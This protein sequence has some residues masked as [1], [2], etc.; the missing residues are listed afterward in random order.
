[1]FDEISFLCICS[2][3]D[4]WTSSTYKHYFLLT[5]LFHYTAS[6]VYIK[7]NSFLHIDQSQFPEGDL[8]WFCG[9]NASVNNTIA[10]NKTILSF[11]ILSATLPIS[12]TYFIHS[13]PSYKN[14]HTTDN[15]CWCPSRTCVY[16]SW[17]QEV[18]PR[19]ASILL[20][21]HST[22]LTCVYWSISTISS[23]LCW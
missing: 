13:L 7:W 17:P 2:L 23:N 16:V 14:T 21:A 22:H 12:V 18:Y 1:M 15:H 8:V 3:Y 11:T 9:A 20:F 10:L 4:S 19:H 6:S 5:F